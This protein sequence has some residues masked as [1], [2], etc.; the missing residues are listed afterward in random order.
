VQEASLPIQ[1]RVER[2]RS[3]LGTAPTLAS[4][5]AV[6]SEL[7]SLR[8][9]FRAERALFDAATLSE[10]KVLAEWAKRGPDP[11][12]LAEMARQ[13]LRETYGYQTFRPGQEQVIASVLGGRDTIG[14]MP[15]GAGKSLTYQIPARI[16]GG[17]TLVVSPLIAL[18]KDQVDALREVGLGATYLNSSLSSG[19]RAERLAG[20]A[21]GEYELLYAA[22]EGL[23]A[24]IGQLL[25]RLDLRLIAVDE[26][27]CI[28]QWGHDFRPAY[29]KL[30]ALKER[31][32]VPILA[33]TATATDAV[34]R[35]IE[36]Q[37]AMDEPTRFRGSFFRKNLR[38]SAFKKGESLGM[39]VQQ[40]ILGVLRERRQQSGIIYCLSR[41]RTEEIASFL[42]S[43]GISAQAY[44]AGLEP[45]ARDRVQDDFRLDRIEVVTATIA[46]GMGI[47]KPNVRFVIHADM[48]RSIEGYYQEVGR[49][50]RDGLLSDCI[51][52]YSFREVTTYDRFAEDSD[53]ELSK[54]RTREQGREMFAFAESLDCRHKAL[55]AYFGEAISSC[56]EA[57]DRC[58]P[59]DFEDA[60]SSARASTRSGPRKR[61]ERPAFG[62]TSRG[63]SADVDQ[64]LYQALR[65]LRRE[66]AEEKNVPAY[67]VFSDATL[68]EMAARRPTTLGEL[69]SISGVGPTKLMRYGEVFLKVMRSTSRG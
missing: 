10:L 18:M 23:E 67:V 42:R 64:D 37:L 49:A 12:A 6:A 53:D 1:Q 30:R 29:R 9:L 38:L 43:E 68:L 60:S 50:G 27:H 19:E 51:L 36:E 40:A 3:L 63:P 46:F 35:D 65:A 11:T 17:T 41:K 14:I 47:D 57:C 44:H 2:L 56:G 58:A 26:A 13:A 31:F 34:M 15:T 54:A 22:P 4:T 61:T 45:A 5:R 59:Q 7:R 33:L 24:S 21:R 52:F 69:G 62:E 20:L 28:S 8:E 32:R 16:L 39:T 48:P 66:L 25:S 55:V